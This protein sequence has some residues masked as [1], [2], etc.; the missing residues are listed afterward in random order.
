M[1]YKLK[2]INYYRWSI[3]KKFVSLVNLLTLKIMGHYFVD[4]VKMS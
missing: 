2:Y 1:S 4:Q 3:F